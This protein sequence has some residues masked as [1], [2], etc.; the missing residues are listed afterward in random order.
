MFHESTTYPGNLALWICPG[1]MCELANGESTL[2]DDERARF[3]DTLD[4]LA[5][6]SY[7]GL[8]PGDDVDAF[9]W[10]DCPTCGSLAGERHEAI[11]TK[12]TPDERAHYMAAHGAL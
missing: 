12:L 7:I 4:E 5:M 8:L 2:T 11:V 10:A 3:Y 9:S 1:C 6:Q